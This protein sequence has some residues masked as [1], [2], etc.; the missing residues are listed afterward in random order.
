MSLVDVVPAEDGGWLLSTREAARRAGVT[1][2][3]IRNWHQA[4]LLEKAGEAPRLGAYWREG[5]VS[6]AGY[7]ARL[8]GREKSGTDPIKLRGGKGSRPRANTGA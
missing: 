2:Q 1:P 3:T 8:A 4:G 7:R 6:R 5:D